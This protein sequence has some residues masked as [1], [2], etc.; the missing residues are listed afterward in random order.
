MISNTAGEFKGCET[1]KNSRFYRVDCR[2]IALERWLSVD[3]NNH[4]N[5]FLC[6]NGRQR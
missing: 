1:I 2:I 6:K 4:H 3:L 5:N